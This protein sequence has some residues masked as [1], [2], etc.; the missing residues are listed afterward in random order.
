MNPGQLDAELKR[1]LRPVYLV[2]GDETLLVQEAVDAIRT[3]AREAGFLERQ[4]F[5]VDSNFNWAALL[6]ANSEQSL[7]TERK[8]LDLRLPTGKPGDEGSRA[9][10]TFCAHTNP[11]T[12]LL[13]TAPRLD[14]SA[15][16]S[17]WY[18][19]L[20]DTGTVVTCWPINAA[21]LP[22]WLAQRLRRTGLRADPDAL[23]LLTDRVQGNL[24]AAAQ[25]V[26]KL[27][28]H[29]DSGTIT[30]AMIAT[31]VGDSARFDVF[32]LV[33]N[34]LSGQAAQALRAL[35]GLRAEGTEAP[36]VLWAVV[37]ELRLLYGCAMERDKGVS[38][39]RALAAARVFPRRQPMIKS[40]LQRLSAP[41]LAAL[42]R[43][44]AAVDRAIKGA[45]EGAPWLMLE[46]ILLALSGAR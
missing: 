13:I 32:A 11:D 8:L 37:R 31:A 34:A 45:D 35:R 7:F 14:A 18:K 21:Q 10:C 42:L 30:A 44:A 36:V 17:K 3:A 24:L 6:A 23:E 15:K 16:R 39:D 25:E 2:S 9:L 27:A 26:D 20:Q 1:G 4:V 29:A 40:A 28:L 5:H 33:D 19:A 22:E 46:D 38:V 43:R 41:R 12:L